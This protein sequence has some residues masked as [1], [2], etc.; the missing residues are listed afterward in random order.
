MSDADA[1]GDG[2]TGRHADDDPTDDEREADAEAAGVGDADAG[3]REDLVVEL[4]GVTK[5]YRSASETV[6]ALDDVSLTVRPGEFVAVV[7]PSGS[8]KSTMLN[9]LG[10]LDVPTRGEQ[11]LQ[12]R[13]V[14]T[15]SD[16]EGTDARK[17]AIGFVFQDFHLIPTLS[18]TENVEL[19][20]LFDDGD[21]S[22]RARELL[23]R[24]GLGDRLDHD[25]TQLSGGQKQR[26][27]IARSLVNRP[28]LVLA[29]EPTGNLDRETGT[30]ILEEF[31]RICDDGVAVVAV[32]H[33]DLVT[34]FADRTVEL[35]DGVLREREGPA[36]GARLATSADGGHETPADAAD[37][38]RERP[39]GGSKDGDGGEDAPATGGGADG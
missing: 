3:G 2:T 1:P 12:G 17:R 35:V 18:A 25:P 28:A 22:D 5:E 39:D 7:G 4:R 37:A 27:A 29:D 13:D 33:D 19:P 38:T 6:V 31:R 10:L 30:T 16:E 24:V 9:V 8:G 23:R 15:L 26:V 36:E 21:A 14:T 32:T 11:Y 20:T 34:E